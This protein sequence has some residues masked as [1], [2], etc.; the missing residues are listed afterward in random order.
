MGRFRVHDLRKPGNCYADFDNIERY[1]QM[2]HARFHN[3]VH[4]QTRAYTCRSWRA[5][6]N[7]TLP[8]ELHWNDEDVPGE[9][10]LGSFGWSVGRN[11]V[12]QIETEFSKGEA[13]RLFIFNSDADLCFEEV[14]EPAD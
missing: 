1:L 14:L 10:F 6:S 8:Y 2:L 13:V 11:L 12:E 3:A 4:A 9:T 7:A 5:A